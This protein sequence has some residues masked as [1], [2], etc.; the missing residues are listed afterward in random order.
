MRVVSL[1]AVVALAGCADY[2]PA[3]Y[4]YPEPSP[5][6]WSEPPV[7]FGGGFLFGDHDRDFRGRG[8]E[9][10]HRDHF[11]RDFDHG[12]EQGQAGQGAPAGQGARAGQ[13]APAGQG[14]HAEQGARAGQGAHAG[15]GA[16]AG[17]GASIGQGGNG[18]RGERYHGGSEPNG[19]H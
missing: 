17:H 14:A 1:A 11:R 3:A 5:W 18:G 12:R 19:P 2:P 9:D 4:T 15:R 7:L 6:Y 8:F 10:Y 16:H 13:G